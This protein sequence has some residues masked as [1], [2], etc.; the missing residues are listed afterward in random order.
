MLCAD[1]PR[2]PGKLLFRSFKNCLCMAVMFFVNLRSSCQE[3]LLIGNVV[4][5]TLFADTGRVT[6]S[7]EF[8]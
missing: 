6:S 7:T 2:G 3:R 8:T 5:S 4:A 1:E